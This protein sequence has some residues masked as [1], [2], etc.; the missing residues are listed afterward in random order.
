[1]G[2]PFRGLQLSA[3]NG[4]HPPHLAPEGL[5]EVCGLIII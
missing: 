2:M 1:L 4:T 3:R 5:A